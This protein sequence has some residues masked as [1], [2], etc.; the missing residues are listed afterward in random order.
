MEHGSNEGLKAERRESAERA[1]T[2]RFNLMLN[3]AIVV[4]LLAVGYLSYAMVIRDTEPA[5]KAA[6]KPPRVIQLDV[7]NG[8]GA[9]GVAAKVTNYLRSGGFD[10]VEM[11]NYKMSNVPHTLVIDRVGDLTAARRVAASLGVAD[12]YVIQQINQDYFVDVSVIIGI[13]Y[14]AL[15][16][17][18]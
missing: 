18:N 5:S 7:L 4:L 10:V 14:A 1:K 15:R 13:D 16:S 12:V 6:A 3:A 8:S 11:K 2:P 9:R 17:S